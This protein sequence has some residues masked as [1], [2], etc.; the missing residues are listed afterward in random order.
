MK[1]TTKLHVRSRGQQKASLTLILGQLFSPT[2]PNFYSKPP[3]AISY[4]KNR[5]R[6][7]KRKTFKR[8]WKKMETLVRVIFLIQ[9]K[10]GRPEKAIPLPKNSMLDTKRNKISC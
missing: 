8:F 1:S 7:T 2:S 9:K 4:Q 3:K 5:G 10:E 6:K